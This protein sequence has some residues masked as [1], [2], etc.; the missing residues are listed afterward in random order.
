MINIK[1][2]KELDYEIYENFKNFRT[3]GVDFGLIIKNEHPEITVGNY[4]RYIDNFYFQNEELLKRSCNEVQALLDKKQ[5]PFLKELNT[6]FGMNFCNNQYTG[7]LSMFNCNPRFIESGTFQIFYKKS[8]AEQLEVIF[9][10]II[11]FAFFEY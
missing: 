11:H 6:L 5:E 2:S 10:E 7:F 4:K 9:H 1:L 8:Y 3:A